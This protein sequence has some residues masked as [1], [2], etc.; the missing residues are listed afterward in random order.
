MPSLKDQESQLPHEKEI[1][2]VKAPL[3]Q[4]RKDFSSLQVYKDTQQSN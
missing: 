1:V 2:E 3:C 4:L